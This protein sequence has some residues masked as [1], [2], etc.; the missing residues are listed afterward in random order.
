LTEAQPTEI[1]AAN[2]SFAEFLETSPP[3][4]ELRVEGLT[5]AGHALGSLVLNRGDVRLHCNSDLC[6]GKGPLH[7]MYVSG[8]VYLKR[9]QREDLFVQYLCRNCQM[10]LKSYAIIARADAQG[11]SGTVYKVGEFP[12]FGPAVPSRVISLIGPDREIFLTGRRA[13]NRGFGIGAFAYYRRVVENQKGR[14]I[15]EMAKVAGKLGASQEDLELFEAAAKE[16]KFSEAIAKINTAIPVSLRI[17][18][19]NPL[20]LLHKAL[21]DGL[22]ERSDAECLECAREIRLVLTDLA[23]RM[24]QVLQEK[25]KLKDAVTKLLERAAKKPPANRE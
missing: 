14:I 15:Q 9:E 23:E 3:D 20:T 2:K 8:E 21:S 24:G 4:S 5:Q 22:H 19:H 17:E 12:A 16:I 1:K 6:E 10:T 7:F 18:G 25:T 11:D 13:E